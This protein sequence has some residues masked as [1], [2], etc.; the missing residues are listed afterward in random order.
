[1]VQLELAF[2]LDLWLHHRRLTYFLQLVCLTTALLVA[3]T[4]SHHRYTPTAFKL[5]SHRVEIIRFK[6]GLIFYKTMVFLTFFNSSVRG[7]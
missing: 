6:M 4:Q 2:K 7:G 3:R 5:K 1:M